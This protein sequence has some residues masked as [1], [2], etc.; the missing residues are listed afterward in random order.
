MRFGEISLA[1]SWSNLTRVFPQAVIMMN[2]DKLLPAEQL[3][4][5][6][7]RHELVAKNRLISKFLPGDTL[8]VVIGEGGHELV[9]KNRLISKFLPCDTPAAVKVG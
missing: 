4:V 5:I 8:A 3:V 1:S 9:A 2:C 7:F 6:V